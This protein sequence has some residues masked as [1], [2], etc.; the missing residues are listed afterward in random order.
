M[1][2]AMF[3]G[4]IIPVVAAQPGHHCKSI[5]R[6]PNWV[7]QT[8]GLIFELHSWFSSHFAAATMSSLFSNGWSVDAEVKW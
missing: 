4:V 7:E 3:Y 5:S 8:N 2:I 6:W 1:Q